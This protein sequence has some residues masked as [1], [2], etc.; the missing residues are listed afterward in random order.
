MQTLRFTSGLLVA[1]TLSACSFLHDVPGVYRI[2]IQQGNVIE[3]EMLQRLEL[4]MSKRKVRFILGTPLLSDAF[5]PDRWD[6]VY[7]YKEGGGEFVQ[8]NISIFFADDVLAEVAG[9]IKLSPRQAEPPPKRRDQIV[10]VEGPGESQGILS[11]LPNPF[12]RD[13][14]EEPRKRKSAT[15]TRATRQQESESSAKSSN[16]I[17]QR[18]TASEQDE[19]D[20]AA[21]PL[22]TRTPAQDGEDTSAKS[23]AEINIEAEQRTSADVQAKEARQGETAQVATG[24]ATQSGGI[25]SRIRERFSLPEGAGDLITIKPPPEDENDRQ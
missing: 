5:H 4:G 1:A 16:S 12:A 14:D 6:Y 19:D 24:A 11:G 2:D 15:W 10:K 23:N 7:T 9:D 3:E 22:A 13:L 25:F 20:E 18:L 8:R 17:W 21:Q